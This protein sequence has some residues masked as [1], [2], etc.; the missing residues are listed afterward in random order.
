MV[1]ATH[2]QMFN[3]RDDEWRPHA[4]HLSPFGARERLEKEGI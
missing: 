4:G 1:A 2:E 3:N